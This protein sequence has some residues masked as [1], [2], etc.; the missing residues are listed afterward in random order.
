MLCFGMFFSFF[1]FCLGLFVFILVDVYYFFSFYY[2]LFFMVCFGFFLLSVVITA[3]LLFTICEC[4]AAM[5]NLLCCGVYF[6]YK[7]LLLFL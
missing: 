4:L 2:L 1:M 5:L 6:C 3:T 7:C